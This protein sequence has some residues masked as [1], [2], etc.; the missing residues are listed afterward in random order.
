MSQIRIS[1]FNIPKE[2]LDN[3][4]LSWWIA[5]TDK[6]T[7]KLARNVKKLRMERKDRLLGEILQQDLPIREFVPVTFS[8]DGAPRSFWDQLDRSR[9]FAF[10]EQSLR[11]RDL[12]ND[13]EYFTPECLEG[14]SEACEIYSESMN[15]LC[16]EYS[17]LVRL[18]IPRE[19]ARGIV[20]LHIV[21]RGSASGNL[22]SLLKLV[23]GR[24][25]YFAQGEYWRPVVQG[26]LEGLWEAIPSLKN[27]NI[28][29]LPCTGKTQCQF[30]KD[31]MDRLDD[32]SNPVCPILIDQLC[33]EEYKFEKFDYDILRNDIITEM[34]HRYPNYIG[35]SLNYANNVGVTLSNWW[36]ELL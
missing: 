22:R 18:G 28:L 11:V 16:M 15:E 10:W 5:R 31:L 34:I 17:S 8:V 27:K 20:P 4:I 13:W 26:L 1:Y 23:S 32:Y 33:P 14:R 24:T 3:V 6:Q 7:E 30:E 21:T 19:M 12:E 2:S 36:N 29:T 35:D 9:D 25:C